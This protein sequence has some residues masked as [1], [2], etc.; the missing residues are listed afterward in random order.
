M[1]NTSNSLLAGGYWGFHRGKPV[2][3]TNQAPSWLFEARA[4]GYERVAQKSREG[5][6]EGRE[7]PPAMPICYK[8][9][10]IGRYRL[11]LVS[12]QI[13]G[14]LSAENFE[15]SVWKPA[16]QIPLKSSSMVLT[17]FRLVR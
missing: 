13:T 12:L 4:P 10:G 7:K 15:C 9:C 2:P 6:G 8:Y 17:E 1:Q 16:E 3:F 11:S 5:E 14:W